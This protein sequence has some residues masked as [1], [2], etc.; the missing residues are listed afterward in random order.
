MATAN[1][2]HV[3]LEMFKEQ[4]HR[5]ATSLTALGEGLGTAALIKGASEVPRNYSDTQYTFRQDSYF[6]YL[7]GYEVPDCFGAVFPDT[8]KGVIF[9][10]RHPESYAVWMGPFPSTEFIKKVTGI[11]EVYYVDEIAH[12]MRT[13][14]VKNIHVLDGINSDSGLEMNVA[15]FKDSESFNII[16][17]VLFEI[18]S[19]QR[20]IKT[21][22][23]IDILTWINK[24]SSEGH[25]AVMKSCRPGMSQHHLEAIFQ[26]HVHYHGG[27]KQ[28]SYACICAT[29]SENATLHYHDN[30]KPAGDG[31]LALLD[32][33]GEYHC[34]ASDITCSFPINGKFTEPQRIIYNAV[35]DAQI[36]CFKAMR[37]GV[38]W[39]DMHKLSLKTMAKHL[40]HNGF[41]NSN[42]TVDIIMS[43]HLMRLFMPHGL[44]HLV[45][46][47]VHDVGGYPAGGNPRPTDP[48]SKCLRTNRM[49][50]EGMFITVEPGLYFNKVLLSEALNNPHESLYLNEAKLREYWDF[51]GV[52]IED[53]VIVTKTGI[54]NLTC[55]PRSCEEIESTMSGSPFAKSP[56]IYKNID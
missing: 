6:Q 34:Y 15:T 53:D 46:L 45:G 56:T 54:I 9:I 50:E 2:Y 44:G 25:I 11:D 5:L 18:L 20:V 37:H 32:M 42:A 40:L 24:V 8:C 16:K 51:G 13:K 39:H 26:Y 28:M 43:N 47:D 4:R 35:L 23:E 36:T 17:S 1:P 41:F 55:C 12:I 14:N 29:G 3:P 33:G 38:M 30:D 19:N 52:R 27:M 48:D 7:F 21:S 31:T 49:L 10:P 22:S